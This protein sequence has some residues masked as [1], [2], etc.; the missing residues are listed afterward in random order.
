MI[1]AHHNDKITPHNEN[2][3]S[4]HIMIQ[5]HYNDKISPHNEKIPHML[6]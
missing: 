2:K 1:Y 4:H 3:K 6:I 5:A